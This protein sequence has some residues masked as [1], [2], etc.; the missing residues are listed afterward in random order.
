MMIPWV[1]A[2]RVKLEWEFQILRN[3]EFDID[4]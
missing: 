1:E 2:F 4:Y 3:L